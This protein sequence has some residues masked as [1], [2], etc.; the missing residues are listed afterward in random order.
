MKRPRKKA[1]VAHRMAAAWLATS[2]GNGLTSIE[3]FFGEIAH[4]PGCCNTGR[5]RMNDRFGNFFIR[6]ILSAG[7]KLIA[8]TNELIRG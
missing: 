1:E 8:L 5:R 4:F 6:F 3:K 2:W 7:D